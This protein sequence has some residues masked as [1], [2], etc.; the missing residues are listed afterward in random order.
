MKKNVLIFPYGQT[1]NNFFIYSKYL[2]DC[3]ENNVKLIILAPDITIKDYSSFLESKYIYFPFYFKFV[4][5]V[6]G[7]K[8]NIKLLNLIFSSKASKIVFFN[9]FKMFPFWHII[10]YN[11][12][13]KYK[14]ENRLKH[15]KTLLQVFKPNDDLTIPIKKMF[16]DVK[17]KNDLI[18]GVHIRRGDYKSFQ[19]GKYYYD[20]KVYHN[21]MLG[22]KELFK[23]KRVSFFISSNENFSFKIFENCNCFSIPKSSAV[24]DLYGLSIADYIIGP[25]STFSGWASFYGN[26]PLVH[27]EKPS[28]QIKLSTFKNILETWK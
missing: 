13:L 11:S 22:V 15:Y 27:V 7:H 10:E 2:S 14:T 5:K 19:N 16:N 17:I 28:D 20:L 6:I 3:I 8:R 26:T 25:P 18:V 23:G 12:M 21:L 9:I 1:C 4:S 24:K